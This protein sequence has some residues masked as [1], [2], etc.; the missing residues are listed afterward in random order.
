MSSSTN[1]VKSIRNIFSLDTL[2]NVAFHRLGIDIWAENNQNLPGN[3][4]LA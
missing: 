3:T 2:F 4:T 1:P